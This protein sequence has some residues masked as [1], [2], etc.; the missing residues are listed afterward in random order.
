M[1]RP[2]RLRLEPRFGQAWRMR[3]AH[4]SH[5][6]TYVPQRLQSARL[7][8]HRLLQRGGRSLRIRMR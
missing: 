5:L 4:R 7:L 2:E 8:V 3:T 6:D 1:K